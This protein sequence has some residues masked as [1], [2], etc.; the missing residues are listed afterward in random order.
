MR[1]VITGAVKMKMR[2][3]LHLVFADGLGDGGYVPCL[4]VTRI[5]RGAGVGESVVDDCIVEEAVV[6]PW[7]VEVAR[8][9][10]GEAAGVLARS[11]GDG[12]VTAAA[13]GRS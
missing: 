4:G 7:E 8:G 6:R 13:V 10:V 9:E 1:K 11:C 2:M 12:V 3:T 5:S